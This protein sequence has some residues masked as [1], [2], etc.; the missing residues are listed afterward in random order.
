MNTLEY[1]YI[2]NETNLEKLILIDLNETQFVKYWIEYLLRLS[3]KVPKVDWYS[4][5]LNST[6]YEGRPAN[7]NVPP[8]IDLLLT[9]TYFQRINIMEKFDDIV[10]ELKSLLVNPSLV[11]QTHLNKWHRIFTRLEHKYLKLEAPMDHH[12]DKKEFWQ[13]VQ[14]IN[15]FTHKLETY[16]YPREERRNPYL[17]QCQFS[18]QFTNANNLNYI[19]AGVFDEQNIER[20]PKDFIF[21]IKTDNFDYD[22]WLHEDITGKDQMKAWLDRDDLTEF[23]ITG[24]IL[25]TPSITLDPYKIYP[26][27]LS[28]EE[29]QRD[30]IASNKPVN[31]YPLGTIRNKDNVDWDKFIN[32]KVVKIKLNDSILWD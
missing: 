31:R 32:C 16:T 27:I 7:E 30:S 12:I 3:A 13:R 25:I 15:T 18:I 21:D 26:G 4:A 28:T 5:I 1:T 2:D 24:N 29:F 17:G 10:N 20:I 19:R 11:E 8:L 22:V 6:R 9:F 23:D 14:D